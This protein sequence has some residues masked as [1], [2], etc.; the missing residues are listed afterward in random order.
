MESRVP[1]G[2]KKQMNR[3]TADP[4]PKKGEIYI[5]I[6]RVQ[7]NAS[8]L[9][10][11]RVDELRRVMFHGCLHLCGYKDKLNEQRAIMR[12]MED[13]YLRLYNLSST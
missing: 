2:M 5:S 13:K 10:L 9:G 12:K 4:L 11:G 7:E 6:E 8:H 3:K 1:Q